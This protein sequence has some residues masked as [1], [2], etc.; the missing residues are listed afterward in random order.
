MSDMKW[1]IESVACNLKQNPQLEI[2]GWI[3][4][5]GGEKV[6]FEILADDKKH[7]PFFVIWEKRQDVTKNVKGA[8]KQK[9]P[10]FSITIDDI[11]SLF[12]VYKELKVYAVTEKKK[13][14]IYSRKFSELYKD[15]KKSTLSLCIDKVALQ[16]KKVI[17]T[18]WMYSKLGA[19]RFEICDNKGKSI[20]HTMERTLR[21]DVLTALG[22][23]EDKMLGMEIVLNVNDI[24]GPRFSIYAKN[25]AVR[26]K[27]TVDLRKVA[28]DA[29]LPGRCWNAAG[30]RQLL[31]NIR[32]IKH[33]G[34]LEFKHEMG[35][36]IRGVST[37]YEIW[38][39]KKQLSEA[40]LERERNE[41]FAICPKYSIVIPLYNTPLNYLEELIDSIVGQ[42]YGNFQLCLADGSTK[43]EVGTFIR[44]KYGEDS[45]IAYRKLA[46]NR[47]IS[48]NTNEAIDMA[49]GDFI[50]LCDHDDTIALNTLYEMTKAINENPDIDVIYTDEDKVTMDGKH[51][52][53]PHFKPDFNL[54]Y[55]RSTNYIC[56]I[57][58]VRKSIVDEVGTL[59]SEYDG[60]QD[61]D[62]ILRCCEKAKCIHHI[63]KVLYHWRSHP[64]STAGNPESKLYAYEAGRK[65]VEAHYKRLG[66]KATVVMTEN[67]GHYRTQFAIEGQPLI[68]IIIP[69][70]DQIRMLDDCLTSIYEKTSY[71]NYEIIIVENNSTEE[72]TFK[73]YEKV[74]G[75]YP[76][77]R[78]ITW[79][80]EFNYAAIN[81]FAVP[82]AKGD[83][84][85]LLNNDVEVITPTWL[86]EMLGY[87]QR[88]DVGVV[89]ARLMY[90]DNSVQ[91]GGV[92]IGLGESRT[93]GHIVG[94]YHYP[95]LTYQEKMR[96]AQDLSAVTGA[97]L[98]TKKSLYQTLGGLDAEN[99]KVAFNDVD[100]CLRVRELGKLVVYNAYISLYHHESVSRGYEQKSGNAKRFEK[101]VHNFKAR[102]GTLIE[103]GDPYYNENMTLDSGY[104][105]VRLTSN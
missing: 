60:A 10:G 98:M 82:Y 53:E 21:P 103:Q 63:P 90:N 48:M 94:D 24:G 17:V 44:K 80:E 38:L 79:K 83:Y 29:S 101:E 104:C 3:V 6:D 100:Y 16:G 95:E 12:K 33:H 105:T 27:Y 54:D 56:H 28:F 96:S 97:C 32:Y 49:E 70:K 23:K 2:S 36:K 35:K 75:R 73:Y 40:E 78:V 45:R 76:N 69:N 92:I 9:T 51:Y 72:K 66:I 47:G 25:K 77:L 81:N 57:F 89:G 34:L 84:L 4:E 74:S 15:Y 43:E 31:W 26:R 39:K 58:V 86:E 93:A 71:K 102:W 99:F 87:C 22:I 19:E 68:S 1:R 62:F 13:K 88:E 18:G 11:K 5:K 37:D 20:A 59:C 64:A 46:E 91:H 61:Y 8:G 52:F 55:L 65:A 50:M 41:K 67:Y 7:I 85:L 30:P 14:C 42:T